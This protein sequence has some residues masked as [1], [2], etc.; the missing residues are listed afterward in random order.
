[1]TSRRRLA[2][3]V[4]ASVALHALVIA[5]TWLPVA[6]PQEELRELEVRLVPLPKMKPERRR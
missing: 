6:Q 2:A 4:L 5:G 1:M 3:A